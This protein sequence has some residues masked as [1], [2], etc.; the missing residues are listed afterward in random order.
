MK[1]KKANR[2][3]ILCRDLDLNPW[4]LNEDPSTVT[5]RPLR[6]TF[7][8]LEMVIN[9]LIHI[10]GMKP[11]EYFSPVNFTEITL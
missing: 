2:K 1:K 7:W 9:S 6:P 5:T 10:V 11:A 3:K 4:T 8:P